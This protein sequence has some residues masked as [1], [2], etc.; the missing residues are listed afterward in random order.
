MIDVEDSYFI[1]CSY[2]LSFPLDSLHLLNITEAS[3]FAGE[4]VFGSFS[5]DI[6]LSSIVLQC[7]KNFFIKQL[8]IHINRQN[9]VCL[10][11]HRI[12]KGQN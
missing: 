1:I 5:N 8:K 10:N 7:K 9:F 6:T 11:S 2:S 4:N 12:K 3:T